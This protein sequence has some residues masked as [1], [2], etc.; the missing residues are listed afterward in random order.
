MKCWAQFR[1]LDPFDSVSISPRSC[2]PDP[3]PIGG[4]YLQQMNRLQNTPGRAR[5]WL[6]RLPAINQ[7][8]NAKGH[9]PTHKLFELGW[10]T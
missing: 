2:N 10:L 3:D 5:K 7:I 9:V 6:A 1:L 8:Q 4:K